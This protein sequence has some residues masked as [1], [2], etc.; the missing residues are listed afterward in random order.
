MK[1][2]VDSLRSQNKYAKFHARSQILDRAIS[3]SMLI[4]NRACPLWFVVA[5]LS[6]SYQGKHNESRFRFEFTCV[7]KWVVWHLLRSAFPSNAK[8][9]KQHPAAQKGKISAFPHTPALH[10][11]SIP[12]IRRQNL[13]RNP[14]QQNYKSLILDFIFAACHINCLRSM[15]NHGG[16]GAKCPF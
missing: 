8:V 15:K 10:L 9:A 6:I 3:S 4:R 13:Q 14:R 16:G 5:R 7:T 2:K 12:S 1:M 11:L